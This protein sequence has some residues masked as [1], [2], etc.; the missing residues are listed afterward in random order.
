MPSIGGKQLQELIL[1]HSFEVSQSSTL[2][3]AGGV[4][5][6]MIVGIFDVLLLTLGGQGEGLGKGLY[7]QTLIL[8]NF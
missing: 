8:N 5:P 3:W 7:L 1:A 2:G 4:A 6:S